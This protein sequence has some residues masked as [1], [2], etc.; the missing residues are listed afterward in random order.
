L[1]EVAIEIKIAAT[2]KLI[3]ALRV[4][5]EGVLISLTADLSALDSKETLIFF[6]T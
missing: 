4:S 2:V 1:R 6:E 3:E 5:K